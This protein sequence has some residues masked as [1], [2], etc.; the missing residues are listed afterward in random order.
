MKV[1]H[2]DAET[3]FSGGEAQVFLLIEGL[4]ELGYENAIL[5]PPGSRAE[6]EAQGRGIPVHPVSMDSDLDLGAIAGL[7]LELMKCRPDI[8][9]LHTGRAT[10]LG[11]LAA[12]MLSLPAITTRRMDK[13]IRHGWRQRLIYGPLVARA[14]AVS[15]AVQEALLA[16]GV[17]PEKVSLIHD[18][19]DVLAQ[20]TPTDRRVVRSALEAS[21]GAIVLL[22]LASLVHRK[23]LDVLLDALSRAREESLTLWIAGD[24]PDRSSLEARS[25]RLGLS[26]R[27]RFL[28][29]RADA[30]DLL[31]ACDIFVL[32]SRREGLGVAALE[33]MAARRPVVASRV[34]GLAEAVVDGKTGMLVPPEDPGALAL[35]LDRL[36][37]DPELRLRLGEAGPARVSEG[38]LASQMVAAYDKL[39]R[40]VL[41]DRIHP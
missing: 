34:G 2:V 3:A 41:A 5:C 38:F 9:H 33:A 27:V 10:W 40:S 1:A 28:G 35:A 12:Q 11:G 14:V 39:Y 22:T 16:G 26:G 37:A 24:G 17:A 29:H 8:V 18:A 23:G 6:A 4:R 13:P 7:R 30:P 20:E 31:A 19:V 36:A 15:L 25:E 21:G 32:P